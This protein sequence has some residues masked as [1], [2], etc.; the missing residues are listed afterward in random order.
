MIDGKSVLAVIPAR[1]NSKGLPGKNLLP[2][3]GKPLIAWSIEVA[4]A[5]KYVDFV[6]VST[7]SEAIAKVSR[8]AG[9]N[10]PFLRPKNLAS[11]TSPTI[12]ALDHA[13]NYCSENLGKEFDLT[14][15]LEPTSPLRDV[16]DVDEALEELN[17][18]QNAESI[19]GVCRT[20]SQNPA[21]LVRRNEAGFLSGYSEGGMKAIRRQDI[22]DIYFFEGSIY[23]STT[24][25]LLER[26]TF[27]HENTVGFV[28]PKWKSLEI[29]DQE[30]FVMAEALMK[31]RGDL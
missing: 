17:S 16:N 12:D 30:D 6:L 19:V 15:L 21:F 29:D 18:A 24:N 1:G 31:L 25:C 2:L 11:D 26:R 23:A 10:V 5:S 22:E 4:L 20:E 7:D 14:V 3:A 27:Y 8:E 28:M 13:I 9:A